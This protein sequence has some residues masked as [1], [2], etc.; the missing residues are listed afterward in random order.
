[1]KTL[2]GWDGWSH[3]PGAQSISWARRLIGE[4]LEK[5]WDLGVWGEGGAPAEAMERTWQEGRAF[6]ISFFFKIL[7]FYLFAR[8]NAH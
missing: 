1:M 6:V 5:R 2:N 7:S 8:E 4:L 3:R